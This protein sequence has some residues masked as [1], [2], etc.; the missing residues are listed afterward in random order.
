MFSCKNPDSCRNEMLRRICI[1]ERF[2]AKNVE[3]IKAAQSNKGTRLRMIENSHS[4]ERENFRMYS[5]NQIIQ[6]FLKGK[7]IYSSFNKTYGEYRFTL[8]Y[9]FRTSADYERPIHL[10]VAAHKSNLLDWTIITVLDPASR[11]FKWDEAYE[12]QI[13][14]CDRHTKLSY[15]Y[16]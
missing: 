15:E 3:I 10:V 13:C 14:F 9:S 12:K 11:K 5:R 7:L 16:N 6:A 2:H 4:T 8:K 1:Q